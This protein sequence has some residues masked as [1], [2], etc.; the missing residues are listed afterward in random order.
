MLPLADAL[1]SVERKDALRWSI[2]K[3]LQDSLVLLLKLR[4]ELF[5]RRLLGP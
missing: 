5:E 1:A 4:L 3:D 2:G